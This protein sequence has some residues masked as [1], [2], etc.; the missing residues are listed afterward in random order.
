LSSTTGDPAPERA[1]QGPPPGDGGQPTSDEPAPDVAAEAEALQVA[2]PSRRAAIL[3]TGLIVAVLFVVFGL[4]LPQSIDYADVIAAFQALT[5][6]QFLAMTGLGIVAW[7]ASGLIFAALVEG[8][9]VVRGT[10][11]WLILAGIGASV[12]L[13]PWNMGVLWV[14]VRGWGIGNTAATSGI[15]LYGVI[16]ILSRM[17]LPL[18]GILALVVAGDVAR[19]ADAGAAWTISVLSA[20]AFIVVTTLIVAIVRSQRIADWLGRTGQRTAEWV[21]RRLGRSGAPDVAGAIH[22]FRNQLGQVI[23]R[24]GFAALVLATVSQA[25]WVFVL[26]VALR[27]C[28]VPEEALSAGVIFAVYALV[29]VITI[30]PIAPG[31]AGVPELLF[32][33]AFTT[34]TGG[35]YEAAITAGVFLYRMYFWFVPI[36]L[37][38]ILMKLARKGKPILPGTSELRDYAKGEAA[39]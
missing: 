13:G 31:G 38:W 26:V 18:L 6:T 7:V 11:S 20:I 22:R 35:E 27:I 9:G 28:G 8:L 15:A 17:V 10:M 33:G 3:R 24:R 16:N 37:A 29:M 2:P 32:I 34:L 14:V 21:L 36:P 30:L 39:A 19:P 5:P 23:R 25:V 4:I 1:P 12:P